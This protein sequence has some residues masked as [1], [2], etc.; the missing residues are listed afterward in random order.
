M[1]IKDNY[2]PKKITEIRSAGRVPAPYEQKNT[3]K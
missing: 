3:V 1:A 2:D